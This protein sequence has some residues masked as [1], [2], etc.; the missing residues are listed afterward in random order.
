MRRRR[1]WWPSPSWPPGASPTCSR[2]PARQESGRRQLRET[3]QILPL[4]V[5]DRVRV[6][7][8]L[9]MTV[10]PSGAEPDQLRG[11]Y[12]VLEAER[13]VDDVLRV[14]AELGHKALEVRD[15]RLVGAHVL[16]DDH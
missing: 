1:P 10:D 11:P 3:P 6:G 9:L 13:D 7:Q 14:L 16:G 4:V 12:V 5:G 15:R 8:R 2:D